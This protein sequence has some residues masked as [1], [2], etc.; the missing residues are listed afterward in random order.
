MMK[1]DEAIELFENNSRMRQRIFIDELINEFK[2]FFRAEDP[3][4]TM[5]CS[6]RRPTVLNN[7]SL[8][9]RLAALDEFKK[10]L[11]AAGWP[12]KTVQFSPVGSAVEIF[13][14]ARQLT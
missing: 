4:N 12:I 10:E 9:I 5:Y 13:L 8:E 3:R 11:I 2:N 6:I 1:Y 7:H 14:E